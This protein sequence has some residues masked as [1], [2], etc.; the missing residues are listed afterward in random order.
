M[1]KERLLSTRKKVE[2]GWLGVSRQLKEEGNM[3]LAAAVHAFVQRMPTA[4]T[5]KE[6]LANEL[7]SCVHAT[8]VRD[9]SR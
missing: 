8:R 6:S 5:E 3:T 7:M 4:W 1:G 9:I 2:A